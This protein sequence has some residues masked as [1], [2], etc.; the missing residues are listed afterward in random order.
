MKS[1]IIVNLVLVSLNAFATRDSRQLPTPPVR[2]PIYY[3]ASAEKMDLEVKKINQKLNRLNELLFEL[4]V[5]AES[6][7]AERK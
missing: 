3:C 4:V 7:E 6:K 5:S 1:V 2:E